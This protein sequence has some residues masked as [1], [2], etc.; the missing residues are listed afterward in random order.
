MKPPEVIW[1]PQ[2]GPQTDF[3]ECPI[4]E[5]FFGGARGGGKT[6]SVL[7]KWLQHCSRWGAR[8]KGIIVRRRLKQLE[9]MI[10]AMRFPTATKVRMIATRRNGPS[11]PGQSAHSDAHQNPPAIAPVT[12]TLRHCQ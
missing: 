7:G 4:A 8:A 5:I 1:Q 6:D 2:P 12:K 11:T 9:D 10:A 3:L